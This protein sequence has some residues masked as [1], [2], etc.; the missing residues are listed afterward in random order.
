MKIKGIHFLL[1]RYMCAAFFKSSSQ[2]IGR[3]ETTLVL[4]QYI[5]TRNDNIRSSQKQKMGGVL[6]GKLWKQN[7]QWGIL[8]SLLRNNSTTPVI[9]MLL[10]QFSSCRNIFSSLYFGY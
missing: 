2:V 5:L 4:L 6:L 3:K 9:F 10:Q 7:V 8:A 1:H